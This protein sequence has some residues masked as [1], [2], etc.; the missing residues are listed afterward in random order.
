MKVAVVG[1]TGM[2]GNV[3]MLVLREM[4]F[5]VDEFIPIASKSS[6][7]KVVRFGEEDFEVVDLEAGL[8]ARPDI[9]LF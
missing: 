1:A 8:A 5:P 7:G 4:N 6:V 2:V 3:M 9:A